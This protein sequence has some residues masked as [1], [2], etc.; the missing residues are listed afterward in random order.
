VAGRYSH[1]FSTPAPLEMICESATLLLFYLLVVYISL[2]GNS[3][4]EIQV[5]V[6]V[7]SQGG[8]DGS[9]DGGSINGM[10]YQP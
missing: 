8:Y 6:E 3:D 7:V 9:S 1:I 2:K 10:L 5:R 4:Q